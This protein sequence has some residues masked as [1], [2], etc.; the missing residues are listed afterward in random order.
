MHGAPKLNPSDL[1]QIAALPLNSHLRIDPWD[2]KVYQLNVK[3]ATLLN[4]GDKMP[5]E[6]TPIFYRLETYQPPAQPVPTSAPAPGPTGAV[7]GNSSN[8]P[9]AATTSEP[10]AATSAP[11]AKPSPG[12]AAQPPA[13]SSGPMEGTSN[14]PPVTPQP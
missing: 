9:T 5:F 14:P 7:E 6:V 11:Q 4:P 13:Q 3:G 2:D 8:A 1:N 10:P 12:T